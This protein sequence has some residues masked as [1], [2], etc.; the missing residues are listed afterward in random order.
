MLLQV[1]EQQA[2]TAQKEAEGTSLAELVEKQADPPKAML[3]EAQAEA[4]AQLAKAKPAPRRSPPSA[5]RKRP[6]FKQKVK[7]RRWCS[8]RR[9]RP[10]STWARPASRTS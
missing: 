4:D 6:R 10:T 5:R 2:L 1:A 3:V 7:L 8:K 9:T